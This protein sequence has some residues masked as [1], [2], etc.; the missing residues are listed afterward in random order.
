MD[1][2]P[3]GSSLSVG[4]PRQGYWSRL[5]FPSL[6]DLP[7]PGSPVSL[8]LAGR[9]FTSK[10]L[11]SP[12][13]LSSSCQMLLNVLLMDSPTA[14]SG[15]GGKGPSILPPHQASGQW[16]TS[17]DAPSGSKDLEPSVWFLA[18]SDQSRPLFTNVIRSHRTTGWLCKPTVLEE[19]SGQAIKGPQPKQLMQKTEAS[20]FISGLWSQ[21]VCRSHCFD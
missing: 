14:E 9:F 6:G 8:A 15:K 4:F 16:V 20:L 10:H 1:C 13:K 3:P 21:K 2:S 11:G 19:G 18:P 7:D 5:P 12:R 17:G